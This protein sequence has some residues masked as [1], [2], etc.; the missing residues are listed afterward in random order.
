MIE[1]KVRL[2]N[3]DHDQSIMTTCLGTYFQRKKQNK[4]NNGERLLHG[5]VCG[6]K[7][8]MVLILENI[9]VSIST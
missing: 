7:K 3:H 5:D 1:G 9:A 8:D 4:K 2:Y 6:K